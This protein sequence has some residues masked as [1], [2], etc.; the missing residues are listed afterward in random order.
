MRTSNFHQAH[1][2]KFYRFYLYHDFDNQLLSN[3]TFVSTDYQSH[4]KGRN[5]RTW[6]SEPGENLMFS[7]LIKD[8]ELLKQSPIISLL[9]AVEVAKVLETYKINT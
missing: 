1:Y 2:S 4:G 3:F 8:K 7:F 9:S 5:D 6:S